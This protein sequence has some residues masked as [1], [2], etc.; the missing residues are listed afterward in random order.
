M[1]LQKTLFGE[2]V[3]DNDFNKIKTLHGDINDVGAKIII[4]RV[5]TMIKSTKIYK[6]INDVLYIGITCNKLKSGLSEYDKESK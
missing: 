2:I 6:D 5:L 3:F 1:H 4:W